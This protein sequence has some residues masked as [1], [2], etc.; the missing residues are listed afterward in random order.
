MWLLCA[1]M[2]HIVPCDVD[3][4]S[5]DI[6]QKHLFGKTI[7][8]EGQLRGRSFQS[9]L[10]G[11]AQLWYDFTVKTQSAAHDIGE[12]GDKECIFRSA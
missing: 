12:E 1:E 7:A 11:F 10:R 8:D 9:G 4:L 5:E 3:R 2:L 6:C